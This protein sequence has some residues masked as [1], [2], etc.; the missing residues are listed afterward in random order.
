MDQATKFGKYAFLLL[1]CALISCSKEKKVTT[2]ES[3]RKEKSLQVPQKTVTLDEVVFDAK[4]SRWLLNSTPYSGYCISKYPNG[5]L[6][7]KFGVIAGRKEGPSETWFVD[8][9]LKSSASYTR[10]KLDGVKSNW[11][12]D[13]THILLSKLNY[14]N[15]KGHGIQRKWYATG[16]PFMVLTLNMGKEEG[17]QK[18][19]RKNGDLYANYE[20]K[21]GR[22]FGMKKAK[23]CFGIE[24]EIV[25][26]E[27]N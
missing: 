15:G 9:H 20:A 10:G 27:G 11:S 13:A 14:Q 24:S 8:G 5:Q 16:E 25:N 2:A 18:A 6:A 1:L 26:Y 23:L 7:E 21:E 3:P 12:P 22:I 17:L 19:F 4:I